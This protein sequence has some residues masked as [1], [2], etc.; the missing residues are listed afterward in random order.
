[1]LSKSIC[2]HCSR[3]AGRRGSP[4]DQAVVCC[5]CSKDYS[6]VVQIARLA[7]RVRE[8]P[9]TPPQV[10]AKLFVRWAELADEPLALAAVKTLITKWAAEDEEDPA[11]KA[12]R[13]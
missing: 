5:L 3:V 13:R 11:E 2:P 1:M 9:G 12:A 4:I 6:R 7:F 10:M 8:V